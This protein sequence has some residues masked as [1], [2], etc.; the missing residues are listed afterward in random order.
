MAIMVGNGAQAGSLS[1]FAPTGIIVNGLMSR[2]GLAGHELAPTWPT[3]WRTRSSRSPAT[4]CSAAGGCSRRVRGPTRRR[5]AGGDAEPF[6]AAHWLTLAVIA[7]LVLVGVLF[8]DSN[9]GMAAF[10]GAVVLALRAADHE[11]AIK[12][13]PWS[14][15]PDGLRRHACWSRCSRR[16]RASICS[17]D[18]L[19]RDLHARHADR[20]HRVRDRHHLGLQQHV[21]RR[22]A[23]VPADRARPD[24]SASAA[25][26]FGDR[27]GDERRRRTWW[28]CRRCRPPA[29]LCIAAL[30][31]GTDCPSF[32][33]A[34]RLGHVDDRHRGVVVLDLLL[35][36]T[37][38][39][40]SDGGTG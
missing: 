24:R 2:I 23:G 11:Q 8:F 37:A 13:M 3:S 4:S 28:T 1:P 38:G 40:E 29:R 12:R 17:R 26:T 20:R 22:A 36:V 16:R 19:A 7:A 34:A 35:V 32:Q 30:P 10:A 21:G 27:L 18:L 39:M 15:D 25:A 9:I 33:Q 14:V 5:T 6:D 31:A